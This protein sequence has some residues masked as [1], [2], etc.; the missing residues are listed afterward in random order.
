MPLF[1]SSNRPVRLAVAPVN[2]PFSCPNSS[3]SNRLAGSAAAFIRTNVRSLRRAAIVDGARDQFLAGAGLAKEQHGRIGRRHRFDSLQHTSQR[4]TLAD[5][6][7]EL[8][9]KLALEVL[10]LVDQVR[11]ATGHFLVGPRVLDG[12]GD[13]RGGLS[14]E[15]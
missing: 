14:E 6:V 15:R 2:A 4:G 10:L 8:L 7:G 12:D 9:V 13:L 11:V 3:L 1:A 5:D